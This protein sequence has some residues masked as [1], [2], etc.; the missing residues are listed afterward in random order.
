MK[1]K[2]RISVS[3]QPKKDGIVSCKRVSIRERFF[4]KLFGPLHKLTILVPGD[5][6]QEVTIIES[7]EKKGETNGKNE[8]SVNHD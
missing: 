8:R 4:T 1:H 3:K 6:V 5:S 7:E 2:L